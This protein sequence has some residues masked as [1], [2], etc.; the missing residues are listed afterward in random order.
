MRHVQRDNSNAQRPLTARAEIVAEIVREISSALA[1]E[2]TMAP[3][4]GGAAATSGEQ[5]PPGRRGGN[6]SS[7]IPQSS[8]GGAHPSESAVGAGSPSSCRGGDGGG[9]CGG[10]DGGEE[11]KGGSPGRRGGSGGSG[12]PPGRV[13]K[14]KRVGGEHRLGEKRRGSFGGVLR[15]EGSILEESDPSRRRAVNSSP[16]G[17]GREGAHPSGGAP[18]TGSPSAQWG[19]PD[20]QGGSGGSEHP[21][22]GVQRE[23][24]PSWKES[25]SCEH[26]SG[27]V[28]SG[29]LSNSDPLPQ[30]VKS[31]CQLFCLSPRQSAE[32]ER[33]TSQS[34]I[35]A[36]SEQRRHGN[37]SLRSQEVGSVSGVGDGVDDRGDGGNLRAQGKKGRWARR[38]SRASKRP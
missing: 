30:A 31:W 22:C 28:Q 8:S 1:G 27:G 23:E 24:R 6:H 25:S 13:Q 21:L 18:G 12:H 37:S 11:G 26:P 2:V 15:K 4:C 32:G 19:S 29:G 9:D 10:G 20:R 36:S 17:A 5:S 34:R 7:L 3:G 35:S 14:R 33:S 16:A 38:Q